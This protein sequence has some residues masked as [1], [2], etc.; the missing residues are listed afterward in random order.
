[1]PSHI[2]QVPFSEED[3]KFRFITPAIQ[4]KWAADQIRMEYPFTDGRVMVRGRKTKRGK[5]KYADYLLSYTDNF[6]LAIVE[7]KDSAHALGSG[8]QQALVYADILDVPFAYSSNGHAFLEHDRLTGTETEIPLDHFPSPGELWERYRAA[9]QLSAAEEKLIDEPYYYQLGCKTPRY[10]QRIA[11]NRTVEAVAKGRQRILLAMATGTGKTYTAFQIAWRLWKGGL[12][13]RILYLADRNILVDQ[14]MREDFTP[15]RN[16]MTKIRGKE[17]DSA[18]ELYFSLYHQLAG[19]EEEEP[20]REF[21]PE[22]FDLVIVDEC[23]RGSAK[24]ESRWRKILEYFSPATHIG[25]TATPKETS[26]VSSSSYFG[27]PLYTYS[28]RQGIDD[29]FLAP[30]KVIR[31]GLDKDLDGYRPEPGKLDKSGEPVEERDYSLREYDR[32]LVIDER[33]ER[34][35]RRITEFL[36]ENDRYAKTIVFCVDTEH[37]ARMRQALISLNSDMVKENPRYVVRITHDEYD[38]DNDL[39]DFTDVKSPYP[40]IVTTSELMSTGVDCKTCKLIVLDKEINSPI[41]F[42]QIIGRGTRLRP[43]YGKEYFTIMDFR[44]ATRMFAN[45][46]FWVPPE[47]D[48][49]FGSGQGGGHGGAGSDHEPREKVHINGV[50]VEIRSERVLYYDADGRMITESLTDYSRKNIL[51]EYA[52]LEDF[53]RAWN[54]TR[55][56]LAILEELEQRGVLLDALREAAGNRDMDDFDLICHIAWDRKPLTRAERAKR[57]RQSGYFDKYEG[58]AREVLAALL[59]KYA[60]FG[61]S[62]LEDT[63]VLSIEPSLSVGGGIAIAREFGGRDKFLQALEELQ[64]QIYAA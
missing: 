63:R 20:F 56:K 30:Y 25:M 60:Q 31:V 62:E 5:R 26:T 9:K 48:E 64:N 28:L 14:A 37:A 17:L 49:N 50:D 36:R 29:G 8:M 15:F 7:A 35:A 27:R 18:F 47:P 46:D 58:V 57:V 39:E 16:V 55:V 23:H 53:L 45:D 41:E 51:G 22:F 52:R 2:K 40:A 6:P 12:K 61:V 32:T 54:G 24:E 21:K 44:G 38:K 4:A 59:E 42:K 19:E 43:D 10:Y 1:M 11:I 34:V 33:T 3:I 13:K